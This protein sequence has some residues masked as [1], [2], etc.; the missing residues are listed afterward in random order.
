[1]YVTERVL[2]INMLTK[3]VLQYLHETL[4]ARHHFLQNVCT[5]MIVYGMKLL[6]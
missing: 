6:C 3:T 2:Y 4:L 1:M 5:S